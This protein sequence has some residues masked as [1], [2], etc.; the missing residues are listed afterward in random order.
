MDR[1]FAIFSDQLNKIPSFQS[2]IFTND[3][4]VTNLRQIEETH[5]KI[6]EIVVDESESIVGFNQEQRR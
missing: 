4:G 1:I 3:A 6:L 2:F 5:C